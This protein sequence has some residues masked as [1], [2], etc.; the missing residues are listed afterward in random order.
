MTKQL[1]LNAERDDVYIIAEANANVFN[2][3]FLAILAIT[4]AGS[5]LLNDVGIFTVE[6]KIIIP[7]ML[8]A[9]VCFLIP[10][11]IY[12]IHDKIMKKTPSVMR[13]PYFKAVILTFI[14]LGILLVGIVLSFHAVL[15]IVIPALMEAQYRYNKKVAIVMLV[16]SLLIVP[17]TVYG[18][19]FWGLADRNFFK[20]M[21]TDAEA[22][23]IARRIDIATPKRMME[24]GLH[25]VIP[26]LLGVAIVNILVIAI[27][28]RNARML[29]RQEILRNVAQEEM[30]RRSNMRGHVIEDLAGVIETRDVGTGEHVVRV[31]KY[32]ELIAR[33]LQ[34][35]EKYKNVLS[36]AEVE[37]LVQAAPLH[38][39][40]KIAVPDH[41]LL[42]PGRF[43][44]EEFEQ[45]KVHAS[46]GGEMIKNIFANLDDEAFLNKAYNIAEF[47]HEKWNGKGYPFGLKGEEIPLEARIMAI[48]D[49]YDALV[50]KRIYKD[51]MAPKEAFEII[52]EEAAQ[53]FDPEIVKA[54]GGMEE[55]FEKIATAE[56]LQDQ[57]PEEKESA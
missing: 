29:D 28:K 55:E 17:I 26:R 45:M 14:Y 49:V 13:A 54:I 16:A 39:V 38:D 19:F 8:T 31:K 33:R 22:S 27:S 7:V 3:K 4:A 9:M 40:G 10:F 53:H 44:P 11:L 15:L 23:D 21:L 57:R 30:E 48:A 35:E 32:V 43:T 2:I 25:Y 46:K 1:D 56:E 34:K 36:D 37:K 20:N 51:P 5:V 47:H 42:K 50:S 12:F 41:I 6:R 52:M 24:I 18:S